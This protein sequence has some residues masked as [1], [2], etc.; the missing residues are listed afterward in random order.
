MINAWTNAN[1][2]G[3]QNLK[4]ALDMLKRSRENTCFTPAGLVACT[5]ADYRGEGT[6]GACAI[7]QIG[8][9]FAYR[10]ED[11][12]YEKGAAL[13]PGLLTAANAITATYYRAGVI[14]I[15]SSG[16]IRVLCGAQGIG[17]KA[18]AVMQLVSVLS[19]T[20]LEDEA[21]IGFFIAGD[22][23]NA[24]LSTASLLVGTDLDVYSCGGMAVASGLSTDGNQLLGAV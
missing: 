21:I 2:L 8:A 19:A 9:S 18:Q 23:T 15:N 3:H 6:Y 10:I 11:T 7:I 16:T 24:F 17:G 5:G 1:Y 4:K 22:G 20:D 13:I 12:M 14:L